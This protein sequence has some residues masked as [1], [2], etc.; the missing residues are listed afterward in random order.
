[1]T[2]VGGTPVEPLDRSQ[3]TLRPVSFAFLLRPFTVGDADPMALSKRR[4][5]DDGVTVN[6]LTTTLSSV[7]VSAV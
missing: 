6:G 3:A 4:L 5:P 7:S 2:G 1:M